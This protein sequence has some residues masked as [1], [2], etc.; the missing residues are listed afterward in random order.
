MMKKQ[1]GLGVLSILLVFD[2]LGMIP[3]VICILAIAIITTC[4]DY[5][6]DHSFTRSQMRWIM[7]NL[8]H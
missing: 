1:I 8:A 4:S 6:V 3:G 5:N 7:M 2:T